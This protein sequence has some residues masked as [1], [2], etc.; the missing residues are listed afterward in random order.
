MYQDQLQWL[1]SN[2]L[3]VWS[4]GCL[5]NF[6]KVVRCCQLN[7]PWPTAQMMEWTSRILVGEMAGADVDFGLEVGQMW[8]IFVRAPT[9][10]PTQH[11]L[12]WPDDPFTTIKYHHLL[13]ISS[14]HIRT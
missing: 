10:H 2:C 9:T 4:V 11:D 7:F 3:C 13:D 5:D 1:G 6:P 12:P 8:L 14:G